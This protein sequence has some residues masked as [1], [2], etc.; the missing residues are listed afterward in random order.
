M[1]IQS[2]KHLFTNIFI[3]TNLDYNP[4]ENLKN[5]LKSIKKKNTKYSFLLLI[6]FN[7]TYKLD[8]IKKT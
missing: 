1:Y 3:F 7:D 2:N 6:T 4:R 8:K 5:I